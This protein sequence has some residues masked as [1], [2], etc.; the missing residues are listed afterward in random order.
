MGVHNHPASLPPMPAIQR[1]LLR[2]A[3]HDRETLEAFLHV[4]IDLLDTLDG[5]TDQEDENDLEPDDDAKGDPAWIE[6]HTRGRHKTGRFNS[7]RI[8]RDCHGSM[9]HEDA[10]DDDP[11]EEDDPSGQCDEDEVNTAF[12]LVRY[13]VGGSGPGCPISDQGGTHGI[14]C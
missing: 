13:T 6:W 10:E 9:L 2:Y 12:A 3:E 1:I 11:R 14:D 5:D 7:E 8:A 4:A